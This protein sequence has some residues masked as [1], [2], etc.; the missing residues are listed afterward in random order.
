MTD[1]LGQS[2]VLPYLKGLHRLG[3][4]FHLISFEKK[5]RFETHGETI[6]GICNESNITWHP[7]HFEL[8]GG[9]KAALCRIKVMK[10]LAKKLQAEHQFDL[11]HCRS[12][13][14]AMI[15]MQL[16]KKFNVPFLFDIR[17]F[18]PD[19]RVDGGLW[20]M[21]NWKYK[22]IYKFFK[23][24][25]TQA[26]RRC[27][28]AISLTENGKE[29]IESWPQL[30]DRM[31]RIDV[32]PCC[33]DLD[34]FDPSTIDHVTR[35][36]L[37]S[38]LEIRDDQFV[39]GYVGSIGTWYMLP[40]M[41]AYFKELKNQRENAVFLLVTKEPKE[42]IL[43]EAKKLDIPVDAL[44]VTS[45]LHSEIPLHISLFDQS[46]FFI[47]STYSKKASSPTKQG[48]IMAMGVPIVCNAGV[49]DTDRI[50]RDH[51]AGAVIENFGTE[52]YR[53]AIEPNWNQNAT[54]QGALKVYSLEEGVKKYHTVYQYIHG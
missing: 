43:A 9:I 18:W 47:R 30:Q 50:I 2:Q 8:D 26:F 46:V 14:P 31:P 34:L 15:G 40:E 22:R 24:K 3:Y 35:K 11:T 32:I 37:K 54:K 12:L 45:S 36:A 49:G 42:E 4:E 44:R 17:G 28:A 23:K 7:Q 27:A 1:P 53:K 21:S 16:K 5:D 39:L 48:E 13:I 51:Q 25:E 10:R 29:E 52:D 6:Q 33:V 38:K 19:E 20:N 41:L